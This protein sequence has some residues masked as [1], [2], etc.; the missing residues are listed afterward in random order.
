[1]DGRRNNLLNVSPPSGK[2]IGAG[3]SFVFINRETQ[4]VVRYDC[5]MLFEMDLKYPCHRSRPLECSY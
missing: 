1:M 4:A 5:C 3:I 2:K